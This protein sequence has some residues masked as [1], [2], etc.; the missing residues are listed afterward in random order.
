MELFFGGLFL[1]VTKRTIMCQLLVV[2]EPELLVLVMFLISRNLTRE[3]E[4]HM[5]LSISAILTASNVFRF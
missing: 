4:Y 3:H 1:R 2:L 5:C